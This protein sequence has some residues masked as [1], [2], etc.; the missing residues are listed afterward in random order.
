[1]AFYFWEDLMQRGKLL[2]TLDLCKVFNLKS[3]S[4]FTNGVLSA[5]ATVKLKEK[6]KAKI[7]CNLGK[8]NCERWY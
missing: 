8:K 1:M 6:L 7:R 5:I 4:L 2:G 3:M